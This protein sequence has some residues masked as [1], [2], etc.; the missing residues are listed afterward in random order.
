MLNRN[1]TK[2]VNWRTR[3]FKWYY[4][5]RHQKWLFQILLILSY[6]VCKE[7]RCQWRSN[8]TEGLTVFPIQGIQDNSL[9]ILWGYNT[10]RKERERQ[11]DRQRKE[12][13]E[14]LIDRLSGW[15]DV[16]LTS[17]IDSIWIQP[18]AKETQGSV[19]VCLY[20]IFFCFFHIVTS[21]KTQ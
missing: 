14:T 16:A 10:E 7:I 18:R 2:Y 12:E 6:T 9:T 19:C 20:L 13:K 5:T 21:Y 15:C 17:C 3:A 1:V 4:K 8:R 11:K